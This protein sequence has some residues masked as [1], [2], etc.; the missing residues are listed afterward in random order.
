[1]LVVRTEQPITRE[2]R[3]KIASFCDV[4]P[5]AVIES[6]DVKTIYSIPLNVQKQNMDQIVLDHFDVQAPKAD[7]SEWIDLEHHV[8]NLSRTI[9]I[10]LVGKYVALQDAYISVTE[11]LKHAG[12]T[13][14]ADIDLKKISAEDVTPENVEELLGDADG[15][16]VPGGFGDRGIEGKITAIK[17]ARENDVPF[18]G[19]CLGM[20]MAS[21]EFARNVLGLKDANSA[22]IDPKTPD[23]IIDL[24]A[25]QEDVEDMGGTQRLGAYPCKLKPGTVAAKAYHNEEVVMER[26]RH[27]YEFN[28][29]YREA[30]AAKGMVFSGTSP[31]NRLVEVIELPKKR[32]F[33]ASQYHP[34][35]LSRPNRPE[36]LFKAFIDAANQT[37]K[38]KA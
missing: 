27:R 30:M 35:F 24:M 26:H 5:E 4:E 20:Q 2:M 1:M 38:V 3:N 11:A 12:Y 14:D 31:D 28:N 22:E 21:V 17:Y 18:L 25:D 32:F 37:G 8:Q 34:E 29:K 13:D 16:L 15:I 7:M 36:G 6:L 23:N 19:I 10:A 33:V 9:K